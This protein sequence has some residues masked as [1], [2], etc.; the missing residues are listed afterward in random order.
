MLSIVSAFFVVMFAANKASNFGRAFLSKIS[1]DLFM[2]S[3][4][5]I[6]T[7]RVVCICMTTNEKCFIAAKR[8]RK[9]NNTFRQANALKYLEI[10]AN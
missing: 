2:K 4:K 5:S 8:T 10:E 6:G 7:M 1:A 3:Q 9:W